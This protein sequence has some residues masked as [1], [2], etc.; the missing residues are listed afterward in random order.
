MKVKETKQISARY[1]LILEEDETFEFETVFDREEWVLQ[2]ED[3]IFVG[4][5]IK[6]GIRYSSEELK[7]ILKV[8]NDL[9]SKHKK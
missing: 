4:E 3:S 5:N 2:G 1:R 8:L 9:N 6:R 7:A